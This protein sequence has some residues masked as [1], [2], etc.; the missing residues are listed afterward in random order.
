MRRRVIHGLM[1]EFSSEE[2]LL[3]ATR[4][5]YE[6]GYRC[7]DAYSPLPIEGLADALG[8]RHT[9]V[10][11][12]VL[13]GGIFGCVGGFGCSIGFRSSTTQSTSAVDRIT[14]GRRSFL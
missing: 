4:T 11:L 8:F 10:P 9:R 6:A 13:I 5:A 3:Q 12:I 7:M 2:S 1:A 14:A